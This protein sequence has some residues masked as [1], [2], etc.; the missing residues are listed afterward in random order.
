MLPTFYVNDA[1]GMAHR[2]HASTKGV[3]NY[4]KPAVF[5]FWVLFWAICG[6][7]FRFLFFL[8]VAGHSG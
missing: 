4:L 6:P 7:F 1:F 3:T 2:A 5:F 8:D